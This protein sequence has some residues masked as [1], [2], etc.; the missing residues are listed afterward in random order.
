MP[1]KHA[2]LGDVIQ[3]LGRCFALDIGLTPRKAKALVTDDGTWVE[4]AEL[5]DE[6]TGEIKLGSARALLSD[7]PLRDLSMPAIDRPVCISFFSPGRN[8]RTGL[9]IFVYDGTANWTIAVFP[10]GGSA[11]ARLC[12]LVRPPRGIVHRD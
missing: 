8:P 12:L 2:T 4:L 5:M 3:A 1:E 6:K 11:V 7:R 9:P 10:E